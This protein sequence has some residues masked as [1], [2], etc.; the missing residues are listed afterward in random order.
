MEIPWSFLTSHSPATPTP[1]GVCPEDPH[2]ALASPVSPSFSL[3]QCGYRWVRWTTTHWPWGAW[4]WGKTVDFGVL[5]RLAGWRASLGFQKTLNPLVAIRYNQCLGVLPLA[6][7]PWAPLLHLCISTILHFRTTSAPRRF[8]ILITCL[9]SKLTVTLEIQWCTPISMPVQAHSF[10]SPVPWLLLPQH[11]LYSLV[12]G[13]QVPIVLTLLQPL[14][15]IDV[16]A[17]SSS[18]R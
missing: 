18:L 16:S 6:H 14:S 2:L 10:S 1:V 9:Q 15:S 12:H 7:C 8:C 13:C 4:A 5:G 11:L 3:F 17:S